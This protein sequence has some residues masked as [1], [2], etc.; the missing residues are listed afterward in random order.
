[1]SAHQI[2]GKLGIGSL[3]GLDSQTYPQNEEFVGVVRFQNK[4]LCSE[5]GFV[6]SGDVFVLFEGELSA[7]VAVLDGF[8]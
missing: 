4:S 3:S 2:E 6:G 5:L 1:M 7:R 8:Q